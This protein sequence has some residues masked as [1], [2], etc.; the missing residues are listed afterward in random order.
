MSITTCPY[1][2]ELIDEDFYAEREEICKEENEQFIKKINQWKKEWKE[3][4]KLK[5]EEYAR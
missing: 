5:E 1:C 2:D 4:H 3:E